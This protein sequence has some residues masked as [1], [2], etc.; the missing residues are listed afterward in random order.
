[1]DYPYDPAVAEAFLERVWRGGRMRDLLDKPGMPSQ[2]AYRHWR[3]THA[4]F[5]ARIAGLRALRYAGGRAHRRWRAFDQTVADRMLVRV[6]RG[7]PWRRMLESDPAMPSR[8]VVY[9]WRFERPMWD[10]AL[11][12]A[13]R[14]GRRAREAMRT[15]QRCAALSEEIGDR[16]VTGASLRSLARDPDMPCARTLYA[17]AARFPAFAAEV[18]SA[19][20]WREDW[21][22][23]QML[24]VSKQ[25]GPFALGLTKRQVAP[26]QRQV[27]R[28]AK[29]PGW[30]RRRE[31]LMSSD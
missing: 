22:N 2:R 26:L 31:A 12:I 19:C 11:K 28:L 27:N 24:E 25:N 17:W 14:F 15:E 4:G 3:A 13:F 1:M 9:R 18:E 30:K 21:F 23:E 6:A 5:R 20:H 29:R 8:A 10:A 7:E 16:I